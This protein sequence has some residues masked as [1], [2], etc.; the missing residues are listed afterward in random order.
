MQNIG[1]IVEIMKAAYT[2]RLN[3]ENAPREHLRHLLQEHL[4]S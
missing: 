1:E 2:T 4:R 3:P